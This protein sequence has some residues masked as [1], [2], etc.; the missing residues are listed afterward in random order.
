MTTFSE[1]KK[2]KQ[3]INKAANATRTSTINIEYE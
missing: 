3:Q 2:L 1:S